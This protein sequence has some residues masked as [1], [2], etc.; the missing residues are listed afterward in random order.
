MH[1]K[2]KG[3]TDRTDYFYFFCPKCKDDQVLRILDYNHVLEE[4]GSRYN[5]QCR[6]K[7]LKSFTFRFE[8]FCETCGLHDCVKVS[9]TGWQA[10]SHAAT[11][12]KLDEKEA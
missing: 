7:A 9:N 8:V 11:L 4:K 3:A 1:G 6:S 12:G 5:D 2:L 10:G